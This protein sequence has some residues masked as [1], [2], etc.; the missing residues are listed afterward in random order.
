MSSPLQFDVVKS[1]NSTVPRYTST[2]PGYVLLPQAP[3]AEPENYTD[4]S[5]TTFF[6]LILHHLNLTFSYVLRDKQIF[7]GKS[8]TVKW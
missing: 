5:F 2:A 6:F 1:S 4:V 3:L 7:L 8:L